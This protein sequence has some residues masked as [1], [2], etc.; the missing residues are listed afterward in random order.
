[1]QTR[2][3][4]SVRRKSARGQIGR[5]ISIS[6]DYLRTLFGSILMFIDFQMKARLVMLIR[7]SEWSR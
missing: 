5:A 1:V 4:D 7:V 3:F 2:Y 6:R